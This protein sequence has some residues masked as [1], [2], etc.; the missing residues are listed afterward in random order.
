MRFYHEPRRYISK[1]AFL[2]FIGALVGFAFAGISTIWSP[3]IKSFDVG[4]ATIG[5]IT[6]ILAGISFLSSFIVVPILEKASKKKICIYSL[7]AILLSYILFSLIKSFALF[8][9]ITIIEVIAIVFKL[10]SWGVIIRNESKLKDIG[11][12]EGLRYTLLNI[13]YV[14][15]PLV[16]GFIAAK[17]GFSI[18]FLVM[19]LILLIALLLFL[20]MKVREPDTIKSSDYNFLKNIYHYFSDSFRLRAYLLKGGMALWWGIVYIFLPLLVLEKGLG[21]E[22]VGIALLG[23]NLPLI[24]LEYPISR[25]ADKI[26]YKGFFIFGFLILAIISFIVFFSSSIY[27]IMALFVISSIGATFIEPLAEAYFFKITPKNIENAYYL[28]FLTS[29]DAGHF[30]GRLIASAAIFFLSFNYIFLILCFEML[31]FAF[32]ACTLKKE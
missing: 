8:L 4:D 13:G 24:V 32:I 25:I 28:P 12:N 10:G 23:I 7:L 17:F 16:V 26:G 27:L 2:A 6:A 15:G 31:F 30:V 1:I 20:N 9:I 3:Y 18:V 29:I 5:L 19:A 11:K 21:I 22:W 14:V